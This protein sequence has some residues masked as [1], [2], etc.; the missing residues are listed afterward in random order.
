[1]NKP[2]KT[3]LLVPIIAALLMS[4]MVCVY[5]A[6]RINY[7]DHSRQRNAISMAYHTLKLPASLKLEKSNWTDD[8]APPE[9]PDN[10][11]WTYT[12]KPTLN[13]AEE[14]NALESTLVSQGFASREQPNIKNSTIYMVDRT[15]DLNITA[16]FIPQPD[17][18]GS[19]DVIK[20]VLI[21]VRQY[22]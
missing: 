19:T 9:L 22:E 15:R 20:N 16:I 7:P 3:R 13:R 21:I 10:F 1:M 5:I 12:Y 4:V 17:H 14:Y 6:L 11:Y 18:V 2:N 8:S